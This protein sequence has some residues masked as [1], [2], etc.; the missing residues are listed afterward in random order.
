MVC[1]SNSQS[2]YNNLHRIHFNADTAATGPHTH[3]APPLDQYLWV[4][5][6]YSVFTENKKRPF[7]L[8]HP[9]SERAAAIPYT[10][11][12]EYALLCLT[13]S[14][15]HLDIW[16]F[17]LNLF[18]RNESGNTFDSV[19]LT[20]AALFVACACRL[21]ANYVVY[22]KYVDSG[23]VRVRHAFDKGSPRPWS[24]TMRYAGDIR[25]FI[26]RIENGFVH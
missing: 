5:V 4:D 10:T 3:T 6:V 7:L 15:E 8:L 1:P 25:Y 12:S 18:S 17:W 26:K 16:F 11:S 20:F 2:T 24:E 9:H 13:N 19:R 23:H 22:A 14:G 21:T